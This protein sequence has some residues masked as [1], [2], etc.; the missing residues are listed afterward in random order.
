MSRLAA[1]K[2]ED[3][4]FGYFA[5]AGAQ[6]VHPRYPLAIGIGVPVKLRGARGPLSAVLQVRMN[7]D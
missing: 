3:S 4:E 7:L 2:G 1:A 5:I 6:W